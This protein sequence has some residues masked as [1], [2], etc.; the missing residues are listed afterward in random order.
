MNALLWGQPRSVAS[1]ASDLAKRE[2]GITPFDCPRDNAPHAIGGDLN[3]CGNGTVPQALHSQRLG[4]PA[5]LTGSQA[6]GCWSAL[7]PQNSYIPAENTSHL[8]AGPVSEPQSAQVYLQAIASFR[9][10]DLIWAGY[11][12]LPVRPWVKSVLCAHSG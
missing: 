11:L 12:E 2:I 1:Q 10:D 3:R 9:R 6:T 8:V 4:G 5:R 7:N